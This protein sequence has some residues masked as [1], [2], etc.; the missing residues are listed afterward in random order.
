MKS[1]INIFC[2]TLTLALLASCNSD[3]GSELANHL[4]FYASFD[5][6]FEAD[7]ALGDPTL[8]IA[9]SLSR[10]AEELE[11][12]DGQNDLG[13]IVED[14]GR[15]GNALYLDLPYDPILFYRGDNNMPYLEQNWSGSV[16]FWMKLD[17]A[18][19]APG[20]SDPIQI[21]SR[22]WNDGALFVDFTDEDPR[23][24]RF[25]IFPDREVWDPEKRDWNDVPIEE[26]PMVDVPEPPFSNDRW[27][28]VAFTFNNFNTGNSDGVVNCYLDGQLFDTLSGREKTITWTPGRVAI[29][30]GYNFRGYLDELSIF[31]RSLTDDEILQIYELEN[32][33]RGL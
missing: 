32:G 5:D 20:Y 17:P 14:E 27:T 9:P 11:P 23:I 2:Y 26:R 16:S 15:Y 24:F 10:A 21:T 3:R 25:A 31:D 1:L 13:R 6:G 8:Y 28:H 18:D 19:L 33:I 29:W 30:L 4:T 22:G 7:I 12:Y